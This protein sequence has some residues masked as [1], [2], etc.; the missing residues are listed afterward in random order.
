MMVSG[1][2]N[3]VHK[4]GVS[5]DGS[6]EMMLQHSSQMMLQKSIT[7]KGIPDMAVGMRHCD[8]RKTS[9]G[10]SYSCKRV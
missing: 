1:Q 9:E 8:D 6:V 2:D 3:R 4:L 10:I 5:V 7:R